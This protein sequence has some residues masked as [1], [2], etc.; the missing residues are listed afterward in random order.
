MSEFN[1][2]VL[3]YVSEKELKPTGGAA[4]YNYNLNKGLQKIGA[5]N[6][7]YLCGVD[8]TRSII[9]ELKDSSIKKFFLCFYEFVIIIVCCIKVNRMQ[10]QI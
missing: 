3:V 6:H 9:K 1:K 4:G 2:R 5:N 10:R 8:N 7:K